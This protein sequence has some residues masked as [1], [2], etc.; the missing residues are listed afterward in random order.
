VAEA[1]EGITITDH[2]MAVGKITDPSNT[3]FVSRIYN[4]RVCTYLSPK[5]IA[6]ELTKKFTK[7]SINNVPLELTPLITRSISVILS[8][9]CPII[10]SAAIE[11]RLA[12]LGVKPTS[13]ISYLQAGISDS[14]YAHTLSFRMQMYIQPA[15]LEKL[16]ESIQLSYEGTNY[17][18]YLTS[19]IL[20]AFSVKKSPSS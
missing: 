13:Q 15:D 11:E 16:S 20:F 4:G 6:E 14:R 18:I 2:I 1:N 19:D 10:P 7:I 8:D 12:V 5:Q 9:V 3:R 17:W